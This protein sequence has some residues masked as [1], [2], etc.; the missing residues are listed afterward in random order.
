MMV[1][2]SVNL[3]DCR[4]YEQV[5]PTEKDGGSG[6]VLVFGTLIPEDQRLP[7]Q[8][9]ADGSAI[10][11]PGEPFFDVRSRGTSQ[12]EEFAQYTSMRSSNGWN[13][14]LGDSLNPEAVPVPVLP[15]SA[16][17]EPR[18]KVLEET[19]TAR[20]SSSSTKNTDP[21]SHQTQTPPKANQIFTNITSQTKNLST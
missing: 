20:R 12:S 6:G 7:F 15:P 11:Y 5:S 2:F 9:T 1:G 17:E 14:T 19:P 3:P 13:T 8:S 4:A 21:A 16:E 10:T 18:A